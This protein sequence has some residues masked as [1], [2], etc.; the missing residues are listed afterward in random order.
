LREQL[1]H[2]DSVPY[3]RDHHEKLEQSKPEANCFPIVSALR[4]DAPRQPY[5]SCD[6]GHHVLSMS[7][8]APSMV[9]DIRNVDLLQTWQN[10]LEWL[11]LAKRWYIIG[12]SFPPEDL[13]IR[14]MFMRAYQGRL[15]SSDKPPEVTVVQYGRDAALESRYRTLFPDCKWIGG[16]LAEFVESTGY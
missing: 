1:R 13:A 5:N 15:D 16:G 7:L 10:A 4:N 9:R 8:V 3:L 14:S 11:R 6:C 12:Y 2:A